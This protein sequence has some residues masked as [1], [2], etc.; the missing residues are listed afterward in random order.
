[1]SDDR[2]ELAELLARYVSIPDTNG[3]DE[4]PPTVFTDPIT[5]DFQSLTGGKPNG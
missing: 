4:I 5:W 3:R 1:M 2:D